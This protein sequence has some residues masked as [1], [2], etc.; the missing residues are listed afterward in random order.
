M[1]PRFAF[2]GSYIAVADTIAAL[3]SRRPP[4]RLAAA[5]RRHLA[6]VTRVASPLSLVAC[7]VDH[8]RPTGIPIDQAVIAGW[9]GRDAAAVE[10]H[11]RELEALGVKRPATTPIFYRVSAAR[12]TTDDTIEA[13]GES[14]GGEVEF[15]LLQHD[16]TALGRRRL[17]P[18][19]PRGREIRRHRLQADVR[20]ADRARFLGLRRRRA[21]L[22]PAD[23]ARA[24]GRRRQAR[25]LPGRRRDRDDGSRER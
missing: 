3:T 2:D 20:E 8:A 10:K 15:V 19:R 18:H 7:Q 14:S 6:G 24:R 9:T 5:D 12:L 13:V 21:A 22:G 11:I 1:T 25:A 16:G 23:P 17:R 4:A